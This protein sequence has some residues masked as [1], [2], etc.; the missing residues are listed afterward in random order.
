MCVCVGE[1]VGLYVCVCVRREWGER[2][3]ERAGNV[4][5]CVLER[6]GLY[7]CVCKRRVGK[8][9]ELVV[10]VCIGVRSEEK[11]VRR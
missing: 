10:C 2:E 3:R 11:G 9:R 4:C 5:V 7:V 6:L 8:E 1:V